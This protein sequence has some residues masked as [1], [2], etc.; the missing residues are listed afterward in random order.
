VPGHAVDRGV[1]FVCDFAARRLYDG[2]DQL[3]GVAI[4]DP[5][6]GFRECCAN[7]ASFDRERPDRSEHISAI[8]RGI[9]SVASDRNLGEQVFDVDAGMRRCADDHR[10]AGKTVAT[11]DAVD[12]ANV[13]GAHD[14]EQRA[15]QSAGIVRQIGRKEERPFGR[16][17]PHHQARYA[18]Q[19]AITL[20]VGC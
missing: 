7:E 13:F 17:A 1:A 18:G 5:Q 8:R 20:S 16:S 15:M 19:H 14:S 2:L 12:L 4:Q 11:S 9:H 10:F 3:A 6:R